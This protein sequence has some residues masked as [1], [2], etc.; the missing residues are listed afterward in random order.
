MKSTYSWDRQIFTGH[1]QEASDFHIQ[2]SDKSHIELFLTDNSGPSL[3]DMASKWMNC[4]LAYSI[5]WM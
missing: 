1:I 5:Q 4:I 3:A 2:A